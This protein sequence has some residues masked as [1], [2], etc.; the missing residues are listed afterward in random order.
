M[1]VLATIGGLLILVALLLPA[2]HRRSLRQLDTITKGPA[3]HD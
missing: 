1:N 3:R 2:P